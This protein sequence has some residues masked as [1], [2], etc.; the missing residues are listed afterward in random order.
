M[1]RKSPFDKKSAEAEERLASFVERE[2]EE[3]QAELQRALAMAR[4]ES[5]A[6]L[7]QEE[8]R[9]AEERRREFV[10]LER[11]ASADLSLKLIETQRLVEERL[12]GWAGDLERAKG[13]L[14]EQ[15]TPLPQPPRQPNQELQKAN[16]R[17][18]HRVGLGA[19]LQPQ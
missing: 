10:E 8:R 13:A 18:V 14:T 9:L 15:L 19:P 12:A 16:L 5:T 7:A 11:Q 3:R 6:L 4:A 1:A 17:G 2:A